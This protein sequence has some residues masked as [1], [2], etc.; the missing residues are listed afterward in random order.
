MATGACAN[1]D[2]SSVPGVVA[3]PGYSV[4]LVLDQLDRPTQMAFASNGD[5]VV[6]E[7]AGPEDS[8]QGRVLLIPADEL[9]TG[10][11]DRRMVL[12]DRLSKPTGVAVVGQTLWIM[13]ERS[14]SYTSLN[15]GAPL[16]TV[17]SGMPFNGRSQGTLTVSDDGALIYNTSGSKRGS[18]V[19]PGSGQIFSMSDADPVGSDIG[20]SDAEVVGSGLKHGYAHTFDSTGQLWATEMTD[21][22]FDE[23]PASDELVKVSAGDNFDWPACVENNRPVTQFNGTPERCAL[24]PPSHALFGPQATPTSVKVAPWDPQVL[25]V[26]LW[27]TDQVV[28]IPIGAQNGAEPWEPEEIVSGVGRP[29]DLLADG[30]RLLLTDHQNGRILAITRS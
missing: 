19:V 11:T 20:P 10:N 13:Q 17:A 9:G 21:G 5:L 7:L 24:A 1:D 22:S 29:Q 16:T 8:G 30:D 15:P 2:S 23:L 6:A 4:S 18:E 3:Q 12:Q 27:V 14:L 28:V 25:V 26:A